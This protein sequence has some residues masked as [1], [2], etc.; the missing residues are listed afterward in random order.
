MITIFS[1]YLSF[2]KLNFSHGT[3]QFYESYL[4][5]FVNHTKIKKL[6]EINDELVLN[7]LNQRKITASNATINKSL[8]V[9]RRLAFF[10]NI[11]LP[12]ISTMKKLKEAKRSFNEVDKNVYE[13][14]KTQIANLNL[15]KNNELFSLMIKILLDTGIRANELL[16][17]QRQ[18]IIYYDT[19]LLEIT[20]SGSQRRVYIRPD[21]YNEIQK[22]ISKHDNQKIFFNILKNRECN[23]NDIKYLMTLLKKIF[24]I[25]SLHAHQFRHSFA[26]TIANNGGN[27]NLLADIMGHSNIK[28]TMRY[29]HPD[30]SK[31][32][33]MVKS[34]LWGLSNG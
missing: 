14:L 29:I 32:K 16:H 25:K 10:Y 1:Y 17:I 12:K 28:T 26:S 21:T 22:F 11:K 30:N 20:K 7:Y 24:K 8:G 19:I 9:I 3:L 34:I 31:A 5:H 15:G 33:E 4:S 18:N 13:T 23:Y 27:V 2:I 6:E